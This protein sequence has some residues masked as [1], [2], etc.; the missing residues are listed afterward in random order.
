MIDSETRPVIEQGLLEVH[1]HLATTGFELSHHAI[2][3]RVV[4]FYDAGQFAAE[5]RRALYTLDLLLEE[6]TAARAK[7]HG[8]IYSHAK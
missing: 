5:A 1:K 4:A 3:T 7:L 6:L 8:A 2:R